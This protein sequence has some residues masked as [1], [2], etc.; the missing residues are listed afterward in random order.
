MRLAFRSTRQERMKSAPRRA[1]GYRRGTVSTLWLKTSGFSWTTFASGISCPRKS[2]V[3]TST[4]Q[5]GASSR[6]ERM[7]PTKALAP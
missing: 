2:G 6:I 1:F 5:S 7:T 3:S 4:A